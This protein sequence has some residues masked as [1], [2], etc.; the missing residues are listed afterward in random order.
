MC[1]GWQPALPRVSAIVSWQSQRETI[2]W[3][4]PQAQPN[5]SLLKSRIQAF[6]QDSHNIFSG[7]RHLAKIGCLEI[8][9]FVVPRSRSFRERVLHGRKIVDRAAALIVG[10]ADGCFRFVKMSVPKRITAFPKERDVFCFGQFAQLQTMCRA[11]SAA[12]AEKN[13]FHRSSIRQKN[14]RA[15]EGARGE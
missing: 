1:A 4:F 15:H 11:E 13:S 12:H 7:R 2:I 3:R 6:P 14:R 10:S 8:E 5:E 9:M